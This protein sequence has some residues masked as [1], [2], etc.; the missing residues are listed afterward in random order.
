MENKFLTTKYLNSDFSAGL[1]VF[2]VALPLCLGIALA[3]GAPLFSGII[4]GILGGLVIGFLSN[5]HVS[6]SGPAAGLAAIVLSSISSLGSFELFLMAVVLS[7]LLQLILGFLK[8]GS[9]SNYFPN[10]VIE[11][12]LAG[13]GVIIFLKQIPHAF[14]Y[15]KDVEG[16][17]AFVEKSGGNTFTTLMES[18]DHISLG[19]TIITLASLFILIMWDKVPALKK[20]KLLPGALVAVLAGITINEIFK[21]SGSSLS[22]DSSHLVNLPVL[23]S[24]SEIGSLITLPDFGGLTNKTVWTVAVT[25]AIVA[26]IETLLC[27][28]ASDR[29]DT[30]K[31]YTSTNTELKAQGIG[32][33]LSGLI[34]GLPMTSVVVRTTA[35]I[36]SGARTKLSAII[37]GVFLLVSVLTIPTLLN[38]IPLATLAAI[39]FLIGYKLANPDKIKKF[40]NQGKFQFIP[41]MATLLAV[42][43]TDLLTGVGI[44]LFISILFIL[45]GNLKRAYYFRKES[46]H[47][48]DVI[49]IDLAQEVSFLNKAAIKLTLGHLPENS[50]V[51][52]D[53]KES[54]YIAHDVLD[55]IK[56][57]KEAGG[58]E[59]GIK[60][61]LTGFKEKYKLENTREENQHTWV[62]NK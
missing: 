35:N 48:G 10:N 3:S 23:A 30:Y 52:I 51:V 21:A 45:Q 4:A 34:G 8:A 36:N 13:I 59:K 15:D 20:I 55:L 41:F 42:V 18:L 27:I 19:A 60:V 47:T 37:H 29:M 1:V 22:L 50:T 61:E 11:G 56:E 31:R 7:G 44:G 14:G 62:G 54:E 49:H 58:P 5:S 28:E 12:M 26:S 33:I 39:L 16:D 40:W 25:L 32:N 38:K 53:A 43:F 17:M 9:I 24:L 57:F 46:Y 2:L 6:V